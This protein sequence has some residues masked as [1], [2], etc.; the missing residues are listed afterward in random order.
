MEISATEIE[1]LHTF[2]IKHFVV[3]YDVRLELVDHLASSIES[4]WTTDASI[5]FDAALD[6]VY[7]SYGKIGFRKLM[8]EK[9]KA[10]EVSSNKG[11]KRALKSLFN[12]PQITLCISLVLVCIYFFSFYKNGNSYVPSYFISVFCTLE[13][14]LSIVILIYIFRMQ[15]TLKYHLISTNIYS[16]FFSVHVFEFLMINK[17]TVWLFLPENLIN[18]PETTISFILFSGMCIFAILLNIAK[19]KYANE[20]FKKTRAVYPMAFK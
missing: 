16:G 11:I 15:K 12:W 10:V 2:C 7:A 3:H 18:K 6:K 1:K 9:E 13:F 20:T 8:Q 14:I 5:P 19:L 17:V 4:I